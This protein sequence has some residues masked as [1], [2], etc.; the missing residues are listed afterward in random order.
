MEICTLFTDEFRL[1]FQSDSRRLCVWREQGTPYY[2]S[3]IHKRDRFGGFNICVWTVISLDGYLVDFCIVPRGA[4]NGHLHRNDGL[5]SIVCLQSDSRRLCVWREQGT[6][7]YPSHIHKR[8]TFG[9]F[10]ICVWTV[11]SLDGY[12]V[13]FYIV[14]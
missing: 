7:Y 2:P 14:P 10:N 6:P 5:D 4:I 11:I 9:G 12:L 13:D 3:H 1:H 8:E